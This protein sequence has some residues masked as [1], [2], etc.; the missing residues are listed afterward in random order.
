M[1]G[2]PPGRRTNAT[3]RNK[4]KLTVPVVFL[5]LQKNTAGVNAHVVC[6]FF[7]TGTRDTTSNN[8]WERLGPLPCCDFAGV[9]AAPR[10]VGRQQRRGFRLAEKPLADGQ[11][12]LVHR[13]SGTLLFNGPAHLDAAFGSAGFA[14]KG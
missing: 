2:T 7:E 3:K 8:S 10:C 13:R 6:G 1:A 14:G 12:L 5:S 11:A 4:P 9:L